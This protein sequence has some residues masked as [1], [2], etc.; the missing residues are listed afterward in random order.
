MY[1][2][3]GKKLSTAL[4]KSQL[5]EFEKLKYMYVGS[6]LLVTTGYFTLYT[7]AE[8]D[9]FYYFEYFLA[10]LITFAGITLCFRNHGGHNQKGF[11][12]N[13][14]CLNVPA[15]IKLYIF[16]W[17]PYF[18]FYQLVNPVTLGWSEE[19][20]FTVYKVSQASLALSSEI[21]F[22][23]IM[24]NYMKLVRANR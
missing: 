24:A 15:S 8:I 11:I 22:Y 19:Y 3:S 20:A 12:E 1:I 16:V 17:L 6:I 23:L 2:W 7:G 10:F 4:A 9:K 14:V 13:F 21:F 5:S 18:L